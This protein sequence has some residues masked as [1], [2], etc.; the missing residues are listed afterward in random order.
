MSWP[1]YICNHINS[2]IWAI[3]QRNRAESF[4]TSFQH[5]FSPFD[6]WM[7]LILA[8]ISKNVLQYL[9]FYAKILRSRFFGSPS[10]FDTH[11]ISE[12]TARFCTIWTQFQCSLFSFY[13]FYS[14]NASISL[15]MAIAWFQT[16]SKKTTTHTLSIVIFS[17]SSIFLSH[18]IIVVIEFN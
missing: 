8:E 4:S 2:S 18:L 1:S 6:I 13:S 3:S 17:C 14:I 9:A 16:N 12:D 5:M 11:Q 15:G 7:G 10:L